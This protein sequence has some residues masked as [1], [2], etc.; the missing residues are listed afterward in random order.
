MGRLYDRSDHATI[1]KLAARYGAERAA[2]IVAGRDAEANADIWR[3]RGIGGAKYVP[4]QKAQP[5]PA[6]AL[7]QAP[8]M[9][10]AA[11]G[12]DPETIAQRLNVSLAIVAKIMK[13]HA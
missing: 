3:W 7:P 1:G 5:R 12:L 6:P 2:E 10:L 13:A 9:A 11:Q 8:V 4:D